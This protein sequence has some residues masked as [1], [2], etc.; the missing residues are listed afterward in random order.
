M[1]LARAM[2][3]AIGGR[4]DVVRLYENQPA[5]CRDCGGCASGGGCRLDDAMDGII[6]RLAESDLLI[7]ASPIHFSSLSAPLIAFFSRLQPFWL[8]RGRMPLPRRPRQAA[9]AVAGGSHYADMFQSARLAATAAFAVLGISFAGMA[10]VAG[11]DARPAGDNPE[12]LAAAAELAGR[13]AAAAASQP[14]AN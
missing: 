1:R 10:T 11:T 14:F 7:A 6:P 12:A 13:M 9:L 3:D 8:A 2:L 5:P 4:N